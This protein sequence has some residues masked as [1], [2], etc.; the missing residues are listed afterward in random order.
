MPTT[1]LQ[2]ADIQASQSQKEVVANQA[3][4]LL[5]KST[6][7]VVS[8]AV[9]GD[10]TLTAVQ[11]RE[12]T[13]V[14][15]T[16]TP[17]SAFTMDMFDTNQRLLVVFNNT[18]AACTV[19]NSAAGGAGQPVIADG[20]VVTFHYDGVDFINFDPPGGGGGKVLQVVNTQTGAVATGTTGLPFDDTIPQNTEGDEFMTAV[21]TP[22]NTANKL[23]IDVVVYGSASATGESIVAALF[24]DAVAGALAAIATD[25]RTGTANDMVSFSFFMT[26]G[27]TS[28]TTF[29]VRAGAQ[30]G[31]F[32][33]NG[34]SGGRKL[35]GVAASSLTITEIEA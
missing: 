26:A 14:E 12:N 24:Q 25:Y 7:Q 28:A 30:S 19:R 23:R 22:G 5:D 29:K 8:I 34:E 2:I 1:H 20:T 9:T 4:D 11:M 18:D 6:N 35:G 16:G 3:H 21:I 15:L 13:I 32:T 33:L 27:T 10:F 31:T 17:G